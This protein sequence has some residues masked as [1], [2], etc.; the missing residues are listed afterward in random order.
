[1]TRVSRKE[2]GRSGIGSDLE[3]NWVHLLWVGSRFGF[4]FNPIS[5][6]RSSHQKIE[7]C[8]EGAYDCQHC[9]EFV[10]FYEKNEILNE[11]EEKERDIMEKEGRKT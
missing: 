8:W 3:L 4:G 6:M 7:L 9:T 11:M 1:M 5:S 2:S 10:P